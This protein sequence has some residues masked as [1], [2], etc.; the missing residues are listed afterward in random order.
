MVGLIKK[1]FYFDMTF[2]SPFL[3]ADDYTLNTKILLKFTGVSD[4]GGVT[5]EWSHAGKNTHGVVV[6]ET[7]AGP[8]K[9]WIHLFSVL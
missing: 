2:Q 9:K 7:W 8:V 3:L 5:H 6:E 4:S 1:Y